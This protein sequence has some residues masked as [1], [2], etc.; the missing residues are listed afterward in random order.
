MLNADLDYDAELYGY[1]KYGGSITGNIHNDKSGRWK[2]GTQIITSTVKDWIRN[3]NGTVIGAQT[4]NT[5]YRIYRAP[6]NEDDAQKVS[7]KTN[8]GCILE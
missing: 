1:A 8:V 4:R 7:L 3:E 6:Y 2:N 5:L